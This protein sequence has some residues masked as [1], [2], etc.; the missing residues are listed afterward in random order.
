MMPDPR[1]PTYES[2]PFR[3]ASPLGRADTLFGRD[4]ELHVLHDQLISDRLVLLHSVS[5]CGKSSLVEA[6]LRKALP[7]I[8]DQSAPTVSLKL[9]TGEHAAK[10][11]VLLARLAPYI[12]L[13]PKPDEPADDE[14]ELEQE[15]QR[16]GSSEERARTLGEVIGPAELTS[17][18]AKR[19]F[20]F[21]DQFEEVLADQSISEEHRIQFFKQLGLLL[22][23]RTLWAVFAIRED[24]L[25]HLQPYLRYLPTHLS[26]RFRLTQLTVE[27]ATSAIECKGKDGCA[28]FNRPVAQEL[29]HNLANQNDQI[30]EPVHLQV[31]CRYLWD[32]LRPHQAIAELPKGLHGTGNFGSVEAALT[33]YYSG[34]IEALTGEDEDAAFKL[35]GWFDRDLMDENAEQRRRVRV[36]SNSGQVTPQQLDGLRERYLIRDDHHS[37]EMSDRV[38]EL[39]H[40]RLLAPVRKSNT[41]FFSTFLQPWIGTAARYAAQPSNELLLD[42]EELSKARKWANSN[43][44]KLTREQVLYLKNSL[45]QRERRRSM[46]RRT[47]QLTAV[48][49]A[50]IL[51]LIS[52]ASWSF[53]ASHVL[54]QQAVE[55]EKSAEL[56]SEH[57]RQ[58]MAEAE[59]VEELARHGMS[60][61]QITTMEADRRIREADQQARTTISRARDEAANSVANA[62]LEA[63]SQVAEAALNSQATINNAAEI[64]REDKER[65][66]SE[67]A[68]LQH[69]GLAF[70]AIG[71]ASETKSLEK[72]I[73]AL[74]EAWQ[75]AN[76][77]VDKG[78]S[79]FALLGR[80][81]ELNRTL[82]SRALLRDTLCLK[83]FVQAVGVVSDIGQ[84]VAVDQNGHLF[85]GIGSMGIDCKNRP[86]G[87]TLANPSVSAVAD[88]A[89]IAGSGAFNGDI[90]T[91]ADVAGPEHAPGSG[92][93]ARASLRQQVVALTFSRDGRYVAAAGAFWA[94]GVWHLESGKMNNVLRW[95]GPAWNPKTLTR[96][97]GIFAT[98]ENK[99]TNVLALSVK[100]GEPQAGRPQGLLAEGWENGCIKLVPVYHDGGHSTSTLLKA[101]CDITSP[102]TA[103]AFSPDGKLLAAG[104][105][106]GRLRLWGL[107]DFPAVK[108][109]QTIKLATRGCHGSVGSITF[110]DG[111]RPM[112]AFGCQESTVNLMDLA[113]LRAPEQLPSTLGSVTGLSYTK[114]YGLLYANGV[115]RFIEAWHVPSEDERADREK[116]RN[117]L[118]EL[119]GQA[120]AN[121][122]RTLETARDVMET[123]CET[124]LLSPGSS[125]CR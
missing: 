29:A 85:S 43:P 36:P 120:A 19:Y 105:R 93:R 84:T 125:A 38:V 14:Y 24:F 22:D 77:K 39:A 58:L 11:N 13:V 34:A 110:L 107:P 45:S 35:R 89:N 73:T 57:S 96:W 9:T 16:R 40:D 10:H 18:P 66:N 3:G 102:V 72:A 75:A 103:I 60:E 69:R 68:G 4:R 81:A 65:S 121:D 20:F 64:Q 80:A 33:A 23:L 6:G 79:S 53:N 71:S 62:K 115:G 118:T 48:V 8:M 2:N 51:A 95:P 70:E 86:A 55:A 49:I 15:R 44:G 28:A 78:E 83:T 52:M 112:L 50:A 99:R 5:G 32:F 91:Q 116:L 27:Q 100:G 92:L 76:F 82:L 114:A 74:T 119:M 42:G 97:L 109:V 25:G 90:V 21:F 17:V 123:L 124:T 106:D 56:A 41:E 30:V 46:A 54:H 59:H 113:P 98:S 101:G 31:V 108:R 117:R 1:L 104:G 37:V 111:E 26:S 12:D 94:V 7:D 122:K 47:T 88:G 87:E 67:I 61:A 63:A